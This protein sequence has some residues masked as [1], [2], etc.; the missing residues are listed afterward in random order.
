M[1]HVLRAGTMLNP[2]P[3]VLVSCGNAEHNNIFTVAWTGTICS[4][5]AMLSI[6]VRP[7]RY[8]YELIRRSMEFTVNLTTAAMARATDYCGVRSGRDRDKWADCALTRAPG[9]AVACPCIAESPVSI[10]CRVRDIIHL[11]THDL[12]IAEVLDV[13]ADDAFIDPDTG[14]LDMGKLEML[15]YCHGKYYAMGR[16][17]GFFGYSIKKK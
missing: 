11:G 12:F 9:V 1:K 7:S 5:P 2:V 8:S 10:E 15:V 16:N 4:D 6:S 17:L 14:A 3:A 13:L